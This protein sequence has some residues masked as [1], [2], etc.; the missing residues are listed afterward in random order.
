M[1]INNL[2][3][4]H[5]AEVT[6]DRTHGTVSFAPQFQKRTILK[7]LTQNQNFFVFL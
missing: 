1:D 6:V 3:A 2:T 4:N 5:S 7:K